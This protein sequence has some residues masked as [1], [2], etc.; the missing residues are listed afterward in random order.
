MT[1][2]VEDVLTNRPVNRANV[3]AHKRAMELDLLLEEVAADIERAPVE[4]WL[5]DEALA[6]LK[7]I[8]ASIAEQQL[9]VNELVE[10]ENALATPAEPDHSWRRMQI[11][12]SLMRA[13]GVFATN[14]EEL[15]KQARVIEAYVNGE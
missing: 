8:D 15:V 9:R 5:K 14:G 10:T 13:Q 11:V 12:E 6:R 4:R 7:R 3:D 1:T 2:E